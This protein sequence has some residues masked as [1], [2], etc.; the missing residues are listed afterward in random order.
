MVHHST[1]N[2]GTDPRT[3]WYQRLEVRPCTLADANRI[4]GVFHRH[5]KPVRGHKF[6]LEGGYGDRLISR[7]EGAI[8]LGRP[9]SR[10]QDDG[11]T[12]E[13][14]RLAT[15]DG[16]P[17]L[18]SCLIGRAVK[19]AKHMGYKRIIT[20][21]LAEEDGAS[22]LAA[23]FQKEADIA[24]GSWDSPSRPRTDKHPVGPKS[25]WV[26]HIPQRGPAI[27][28]AGSRTVLLRS[29]RTVLFWARTKNGFNEVWKAGE[30]GIELAGRFPFPPAA[31][32]PVPRK[33]SP[34]YRLE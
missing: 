20:Y 28:P 25:R 12:L 32:A 23:G 17:N 7:G 11:V 34:R 22:L 30:K 4:I 31:Q 10:H 5:H 18:A 14:T 13:I 1:V 19:L 24:G 6:S 9:V 33:K 27:A 26:R 29:G 21:V 15:M 3:G 8:I 16:S 2:E